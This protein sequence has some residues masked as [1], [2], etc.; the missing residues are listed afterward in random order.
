M[1]GGKACGTGGCKASTTGVGDR[2]GHLV[3][4]ELVGDEVDGLG[5]GVWH[6]EE[7]MAQSAMLY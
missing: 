5:G 2:V 6:T 4:G 7:H 1:S 3:G